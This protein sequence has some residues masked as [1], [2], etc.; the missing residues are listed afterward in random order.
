M[1]DRLRQ[2]VTSSKEVEGNS[3]R[4]Q[5]C[6]FLHNPLHDY[7]SIWW[8]ATWALFRCRP[9]HIYPEGSEDPQTRAMEEIFGK[10]RNTVIITQGTFEGY[11]GSLP[12]VLHP[13]FNTLEIFREELVVT[14]RDYEKSFDGSIVL[15]KVENF[16]LCLEALVQS[17]DEV[18][19]YDFSVI[20]ALERPPLDTSLVMP[21]ESEE[22]STE[23][24][25]AGG[26]IL[27]RRLAIVAQSDGG[28]GEEQEA[29]TGGVK[30]VMY[31]SAE[32][33][34]SDVFLSAPTDG[35]DSL[36][37]KYELQPLPNKRKAS[38]SSISEQPSRRT[39]VFD[40]DLPDHDP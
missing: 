16:R 22:N 26:R 31:E 2:V 11:R 25:K 21:E 27:D 8:I 17:A 7:E 23:G 37:K 29:M 33:D 14:Y 39:K 15:S 40:S 3:K 32:D 36:P 6:V 24:Q 20:S 5:K 13:L 18:R 9:K 10:H 30:R 12:D 34:T 28:T 19:L 4:A 35:G 38:V 1:K